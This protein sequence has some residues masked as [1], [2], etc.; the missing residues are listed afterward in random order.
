[1][2]AFNVKPCYK[3]W[4][5]PPEIVAATIHMRPYSAQISRHQCKTTTTFGLRW[6]RGSRPIGLFDMVG[7]RRYIPLDH[8]IW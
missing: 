6:L 5:F 8:I 2:N 3:G 7:R 4:R 1:M